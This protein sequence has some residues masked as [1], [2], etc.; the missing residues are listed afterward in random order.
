MLYFNS[1]NGLLCFG[2]FVF[3]AGR[4]L[5]SFRAFPPGYFFAKNNYFFCLSQPLRRP[6]VLRRSCERL[7]L[8]VEPNPG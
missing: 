3:P 6:F 5:F 7:F 8:H 1:T 2:F 4:G